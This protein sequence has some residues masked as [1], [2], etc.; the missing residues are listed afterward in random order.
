MDDSKQTDNMNQT[1]EYS[2]QRSLEILL[3]RV[4]TLWG[5]YH[6]GGASVIIWSAFEDISRI[7]YLK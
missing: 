4:S 1:I 5:A 2:P 7:A 6:F 3:F